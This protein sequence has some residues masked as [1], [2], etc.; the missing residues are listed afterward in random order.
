[1][2]YKPNNRR[3]ALLVALADYGPGNLTADDITDELTAE[4]IA[5]AILR[6]EGS[7]RR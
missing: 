6:R 1:V 2:S 7:I 3:E 4:Q 5:E